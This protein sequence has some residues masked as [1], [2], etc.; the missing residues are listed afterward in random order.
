MFTL[1]VAYDSKKGIGLNNDIPWNYPEDLRRFSTI[2]KGNVVIMG[3]KTYE[4]IPIKYRPL[5][6]RINIVI[7]K[8][9]KPKHVPSNVVWV[10]SIDAANTIAIANESSKIY[11]IGGASIYQQYLKNKLITNMLVSEI[12]KDYKC[13]TFFPDTAGFELINTVTSENHPFEL[14]YKTYTHQI[15]YEEIKYL[16]LIKDVIRNG[17]FRND[18]TGVGTF[19]LF[20]KQLRF[21]LS[22]NTIPLLTTKKTYWKGIVKELLWFMRGDT[23]AKILDK[24]GVK[25]WNANGTRE[26]LD[27]RG[28]DYPEGQLGPVYGWQW[29]NFGQPYT[30]YKKKAKEAANKEYQYDYF[31]LDREAQREVE[32]EICQGISK[33]ERRQVVDKL[34]EQQNEPTTNIKNKYL[35]HYYNQYER[36]TPAAHGKEYADQLKNVIEL[37]KKDPTTRRAIISAWNPNQLDKMAL[38]PCH[39][40]YQFWISNNKKLH[41]SVFQRSGDIGLGIPF[42]IASASLFTHLIARATGN[43]AVELVHFIS[44]AHVYSNHVEALQKQVLRVPVKFPTIEISND[45]PKEDIWNIKYKHIKLKN[46]DYAPPIHMKMAV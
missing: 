18:R 22:N 35:F 21:N 2:T 33:I 36:R 19:S 10:S 31:N 25:F 4:S 15:N 17:T 41:C 43:V 30:L 11:V 29:R 39:V 16:S 5:P 37:L 12:S 8:S 3:R 26:F 6:N 44:D 28:L 42:N 1:V 13:D 14:T 7:S 38:P 9:P 34:C 45:A 32:E 23:D 27:N 20:G 40:L 46:Y 24:D